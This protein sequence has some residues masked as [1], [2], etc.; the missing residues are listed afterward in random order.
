MTTADLIR[1]MRR[2]RG[3]HPLG[4]DANRQRPSDAAR[5]DLGFD[6]VRGAGWAS[7]A[8]HEHTGGHGSRYIPLGH[9][10][11]RAHPTTPAGEL[12][13]PTVPPLVLV[14][15]SQRSQR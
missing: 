11:A 8:A 4:R 12:F 14:A 9:T 15:L 6:A 7:A 1:S 2:R 3:Q 13:S 5:Q 10:A